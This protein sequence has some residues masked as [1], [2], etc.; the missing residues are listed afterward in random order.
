MNARGAA[1]ALASLLALVQP[2]RAQDESARAQDGDALAFTGH[3]FPQA[4]EALEPVWGDLRA[5]EKRLARAVVARV[6]L[7][8][9]SLEGA[10]PPARVAW[11]TM[12]DRALG[13]VLG[14]LGEG[15]PHRLN[16]ASVEV[17]LDAVFSDAV[18]VAGADRL[19]PRSAHRTDS[20]VHP[21]RCRREERGKQALRD[22][23]V[24]A[25]ATALRLRQDE[26][27]ALG[28]DLFDA[29]ARA[30]AETVRALRVER[31][32]AGWSE[33][34]TPE[35]KHRLTRMAHGHGRGL[36]RRS[37]RTGDELELA[38]GRYPEDDFVLEAIAVVRVRGWDRSA[39]ARLER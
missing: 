14:E 17:A 1:L 13:R 4:W 39:L 22:Y 11:I 9:E 32:D 21:A 18:V 36:R 2:A 28:G 7:D 20:T 16:A 34:L 30:D 6:D 26:V 3:R 5:Q 27:N 10:L 25:H 35:R 19:F 33:V 29:L 12:L 8:V 24:V 38:R 15:R 23:V 31:I 37:D